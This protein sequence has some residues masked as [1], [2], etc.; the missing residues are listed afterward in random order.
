MAILKRTPRSEISRGTRT[1]S[2]P[3]PHLTAG[4]SAATVEVE[5][6][7]NIVVESKMGADASGNVGVKWKWDY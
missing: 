2:G 1:Q 4:S 7:D 3:V 6:T 5:V